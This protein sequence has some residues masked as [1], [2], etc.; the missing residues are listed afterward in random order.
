MHAKRWTR[1]LAERVYFFFMTG[2]GISCMRY[3]EIGVG[4]GEGAGA[5]V[6]GAAAGRTQRRHAAA[7]HAGGQVGRRHAAHAAPGHP[8]DVVMARLV[9]RQ[10]LVHLGTRLA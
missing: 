4:A 1:G 7:H 5:R 3:P 10:R 2:V 6:E 9:D 8:V